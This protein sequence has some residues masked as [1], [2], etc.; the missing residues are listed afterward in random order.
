MLLCIPC[1][2]RADSCFL[3]FIHR[4]VPTTPEPP[5]TTSATTAVTPAP[6]RVVLLRATL[7]TTFEEA[8]RDDSSPEF[9]A[10][11]SRVET[12]V[13]IENENERLS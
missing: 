5:T 1:R 7:N 3:L 2:P 9:E 8:L 4:T 11:S 12:T 10:L 13:G 6:G